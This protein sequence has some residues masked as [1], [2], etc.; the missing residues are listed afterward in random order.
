MIKTKQVGFTLLEL[1]IALALGLLI[2]AAG[3]SVFLSGQRSISLQ[4]SMNE[5]QQN[6]NFGL[7]FI[8]HDLRHANL[9]TPST[10]RINNKQVGSGIIFNTNN[11]P[12]SLSGVDTFLFTSQSKDEAATSTESDQIT[13]QYIPQYTE[14]TVDEEYRE[15]GEKKTRQIKKYISQNSDCEGN[16]LEFTEQR[17]IVQRYYLKEDSRQ[18]PGQPKIYSIYCDAG[19]YV[20]GESLISGITNATDGQQIMQNIDAFKVRFGVKTTSG[21]FR[22][23]TI[24]QYL[25]VMGNTVTLSQNFY[26][27]MSVE[28]GVI[29]KSTNPLSSEGAIN[30]SK[31]FK[32][33]GNDLSLDNDHING[34][35]YLREVFS[36]LV[37]FRNTLGAS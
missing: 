15:D 1:M 2:V 11:L 24:N 6:A 23:M 32:V 13:I 3:I 4:T 9:N 35:K 27:I 36:Q 7:G 30:N 21:D 31:I 20:D 14:I 18:V 29:A 28:I 16:N 34:P 19:N 12:S 8:T 17:I 26:N 25:A 22:Y 10:Q 33:V 37:A 5:L